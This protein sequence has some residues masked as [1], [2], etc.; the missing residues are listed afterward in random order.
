MTSSTNANDGATKSKIPSVKDIDLV[1]D[2]LYRIRECNHVPLDIKSNL[3]DFVVEGKSVGKVTKSVAE[4]LCGTGEIFIMEQ[5]LI[6]EKAILTLSN[7]AGAT[8]EARTDSVMSVMES[9]R[10]QGIIEGW[11]DE[12]LPLAN[13]FYDEPVLLVERAAA[14][15]LGMQQYGVHINGI[16]KC[17]DG[18]EKMW[19]ARRSNTKSKYPGMLDHIVAGGQPAGLSLM[20]NVLKE[21]AEEAGIEESITMECIRAAGAVSYEQFEPSNCDHYDGVVSRALLFNYELYLPRD[22]VPKVVDGEV[23]E[24]FTWTMAEVM[25][26][27]K[28]DYED[29]IKPN[30]YLVIIDFLL[31][32]GYLSPEIPGYLHIMRELRGGYC[33]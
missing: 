11:R 3:M 5:S 13:G 6:D 28:K 10:N 4:L 23:E 7:K 25:E 12:L 1:Q 17:D 9:L 20:E 26:S 33:G 19:M 2:M 30:C 21:C 24:F 15:F 14:P 8:L 29:P 22:F 16:V 31:R 32:K 18:N 27:M